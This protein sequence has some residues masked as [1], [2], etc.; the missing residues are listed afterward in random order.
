MAD[1][2]YKKIV[3]ELQQ[4]EEGYPPDK[5]ESLWAFEKQPGLYCVDNIPFYVKGISSGDVISA[6]EKRDQLWFKNLIVPSSNSVFRLYISDIA[7]VQVARDEFRALGCE[8]E[9]SNLPKLVAVEVPD[10]VNF[11]PVGNLLRLGADRGRWE[12]EEGVL[13]HE[14][15]I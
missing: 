9:L 5:S 13:R 6:E 14:I 2:K 4:D 3:F 1:E 8:T 10:K 7:D 12:Y 11:E 15:A